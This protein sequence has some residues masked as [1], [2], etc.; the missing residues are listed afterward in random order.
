[1][2]FR[3]ESIALLTTNMKSKKLTEVLLRPAIRSQHVVLAKYSI[4]RPTGEI[5]FFVYDSNRPFKDVVVTYDPKTQH[6]YAPE[7]VEYFKIERPNDPVGVFLV[8]EVDRDPLINT[9]LIYYTRHCEALNWAT[10]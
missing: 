8:D 4:T 1:M 5:D 7:I 3:S 2:L 9:A 10:N 6:F